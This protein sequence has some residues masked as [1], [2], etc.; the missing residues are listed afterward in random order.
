MKVILFILSSL[1]S[2]NTYA[3]TR[4][5]SSVRTGT[6]MLDGFVM[7]RTKD[8]QIETVKHTKA[9]YDVVWIDSCTYEL[10]NPTL[11]KGDPKIIGKPT[12]V[13]RVEIKSIK[14]REISLHTTTNFTKDTYDFI[15]HKK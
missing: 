2:I 14:G 10:R 1:I 4:D 3:Q 11:I 7:K 13:Y 8:K 9:K 5:C 6:F 15:V 12:D